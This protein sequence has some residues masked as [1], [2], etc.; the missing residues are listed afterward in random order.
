MYGWF[1]KLG[2]MAK[3]K[4]CVEFFG[5]L[6][7]R[8][9]QRSWKPSTARSWEFESLTLRQ[10][11]VTAKLFGNIIDWKSMRCVVCPLLK[12]VQVHQMDVRLDFWGISE[13]ASHFTVYEVAPDRPRYTPPMWLQRLLEWRFLL[14]C[15]QPYR[16][17]WVDYRSVAQPGES[18]ILISCWSVVQ[19]HSLLPFKIHTAIFILPCKPWVMGSN[20]IRQ[21]LL[22]V[23]QSGRATYIVVW[24]LGSCWF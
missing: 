19:I 22:V 12:V 13:T 23:A 15:V 7:E 17:H 18:S 2:N 14:A 9:L 11:R 5:E 24:P 4:Q 6:A 21:Q 20:P 1:S 3:A 10:R 8:L 16:L